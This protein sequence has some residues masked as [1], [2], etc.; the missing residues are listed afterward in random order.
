MIHDCHEG[1]TQARDEV[2]ACQSLLLA[3]GGGEDDRALALNGH[4]RTIAKADH[5]GD[6]LV[7]LGEDI[8]PAGHVV[9]CTGIKVPLISLA[10]AIR[11]EVEL[12]AWLLQMDF[13][14]SRGALFWRSRAPFLW[15][16]TAEQSA[17]FW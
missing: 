12:G 14:Q 8:S 16:G 9:R 13:K 3:A 15:S 1:E 10:V 17:L 11:V 6:V 2:D 5:A 7:K 4:Q